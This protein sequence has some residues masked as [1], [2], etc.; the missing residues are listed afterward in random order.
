MVLLSA[1][2]VSSSRMTMGEPAAAAAAAAEEGRVALMRGLVL[3]HS[4]WGV[5]VVLLTTATSSPEMS[6]QKRFCP[7]AAAPA[8]PVASA[9]AAGCSSM[10]Q[11]QKE[12]QPQARERDEGAK[13]GK[14]NL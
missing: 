6:S 2:G 7:V 3:P 11:Q 8:W 14:M 4:S 1:A 12:G 10:V 5:G 9:A 13:L